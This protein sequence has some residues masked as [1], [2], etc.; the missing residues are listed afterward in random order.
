[1]DL[2][3]PFSLLFERILARLVA[4]VPELRYINQELGQLEEDRPPVTYPCALIDM[5]EFQFSEIGNKPRQLA[6]GFVVLRLAFKTYSSSSNLTTEAVREKALE[7]YEI[8][9]KIMSKLHNWAPE[10]FG[11][12]LRRKATTEKRDDNKRVRIMPFAVNF[13]DSGAVPVYTITARPNP[14]ILEEKK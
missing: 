5:D 6:D 14:L 7:F 2:Q 8:E 9:Y 3:S 12:L 4:E 10:G 13:E 11:R 1:M